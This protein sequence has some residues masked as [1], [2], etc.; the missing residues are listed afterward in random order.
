MSN[1]INDFKTNKLKNLNN[2]Y[3]RVLL[4]V[5]NNYNIE[6]RNVNRLRINVRQKQLFVNNINKKYEQIRNNVKIFFENEI[7]KTNSISLPNPI[8]FSLQESNKKALVIGINY[9]G[10]SS[11]LN[12]CIND[13]KSIET[14]LTEK[15]FTQIQMLTDETILKPTRANIL[16]E[17]KNLLETSNKNDTLFIYYSGHGS[18]TLDRNGDELDGRDEVIVP[19]DFNYIK[20]DEIKSIINTYGK[21]D[22][23]LIA[24]FD[25]C[26]SGTALDLKY[27]ILEKLNYDDITENER[28]SETPCST[29]FI[30]GCRDE[31]VSL[32]T[33]IND[34]VQGLMTWSFLETVKTNNTITW[35]N[36]VKQMREKL[37]PVSYQIPQLSSGKLFNPDN[38]FAL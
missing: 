31:Q 22:T 6:N 18:Y 8:E 21:A 5:N 9:I 4:I 26:N 34:K 32:E 30:S 16:N 12:G 11:R 35:R 38:D 36:L 14:Y 15:G 29:L 25:C 37:K 19:L 10:T 33:V 20:D 13:A 24:F 17:I 28:N 2:S 3:N 27:Q 7:K 23:N 1:L